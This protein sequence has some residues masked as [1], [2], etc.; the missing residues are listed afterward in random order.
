MEQHKKSDGICT[1]NR[2][3]Y[4]SAVH[5]RRSLRLKHQQRGK[6]KERKRQRDANANHKRT[7]QRRK[8]IFIFTTPSDALVSESLYFCG[9]KTE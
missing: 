8:I 9:N 5:K 4:D 2:F 3:G 1:L 6:K 7:Q